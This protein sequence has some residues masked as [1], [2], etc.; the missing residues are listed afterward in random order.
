MTETPV[1]IGIDPGLTGGI[2]ILKGSRLLQ[3]QRMPVRTHNKK[4]RID[5]HALLQL[6]GALRNQYPGVCAIVERSQAA[7]GQSVPAMFAY[8]M[9][10]GVLTTS[11]IAS[12]ISYVEVTPVTWKRRMGF[13]T[14]APKRYSLNEARQRFPDKAHLFSKAGD[15]G[16]AEA[17][18]IGLCGQWDK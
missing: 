14:G 16:V 1:T 12:G 11:L 7:P 5:A 13:P 9:G 2:A 17:A 3:A 8:G 15:D 18:L 6:F 10:Y 4:R